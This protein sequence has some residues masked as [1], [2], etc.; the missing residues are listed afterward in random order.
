MAT[1]AQEG[2]SEKEIPKLHKLGSRSNQI[3]FYCT[4]IS[5]DQNNNLHHQLIEVSNH[6]PH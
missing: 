5:P 4:G 6:V 1:I 2:K 3:L